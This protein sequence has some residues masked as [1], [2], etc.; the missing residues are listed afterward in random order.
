MSK[1]HY[2]HRQ[3]GKLWPFAVL[4]AI[5]QISILAVFGDEMALVGIISTVVGCLVLIIVL[6]AFSRLTVRVSDDDVHLSFG[7][8]WP[9][10]RIA[11]AEIVDHTPVRNSWLH[12]WGIRWFKGGRMWNVWGLDAVELELASGKKFR[13]GT[14]EP[15]KLDAALDTQ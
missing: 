7:S 1:P 8:G 4:Y 13:I 2:E 5:A 15:K 11:R 12:G 9:R 3:Y 10:K 6:L 14:D